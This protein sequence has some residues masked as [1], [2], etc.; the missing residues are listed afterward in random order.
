MNAHDVIV[1]NCALE[2]VNSGIILLK[3]LFD[4]ISVFVEYLELSM[5]LEI[6]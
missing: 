5:G 1:V 4:I 6:Y 3:E 2:D